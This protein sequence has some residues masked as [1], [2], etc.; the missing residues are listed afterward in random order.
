MWRALR[1][2]RARSIVGTAGALAVGF[3]AGSKDQEQR[4]RQLPAGFNACACCD[5]RPLSETQQALRP[6]LESIVGAANVKSDVQQKGSRMGEGRAFAVVKPCTIEQALKVLQE[7]VD[8]DVC[9][10]PQGANTGLTGGSVPRGAG[11]SLNRPTVVINMEQL[12]S[13]MPIDNGERIVCLAGAGIYDVLLRAESLGRESH[14]ILGSI[15]LN[16]TTAAGIAFGSGGTQ[17]CKGP[18]Y[19]ERLLYAQVGED[20]AVLLHNSLGLLGSGSE[21]YRKLESGS[22]T[23][24]DVD[25]H[26]HL[27]ASQR[28][29]KNDVCK[30]DGSVARCNADTRGPDACRSEG[31]VMILAS[32]HDTFEKPQTSDTLWIAC[33]D[34]TTA[35][36]LKAQVN[37]AGGVAD[38]PGSCEY[39]DKDAVR[40]V[41]EAGRII[42]WMIRGV[43]IGPT[44]KALWDVKLKFEASPLPFAAVVVDKLMFAFNPLFPRTLPAPILELTGACDHHLLINVA[45]YGGGE[46]KRFFERL[47]RFA[48]SHPIIVHKCSHTEKEAINYFRFAAAPA[49]RT[50]CVGSGLEGFST[51]YGLPKVFTGIP[52][53]EDDKLALR[54]RYS[55]FGCNVVHE[56]VCVKPGVDAH[57]A[58]MDLKQAVE[59]IEGMLPAE[60]GHGTEYNAPP[61]T[62]TRWKAMDPLNVFN[63]G[64]GGTSTERR[65]GDGAAA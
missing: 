2:P 4:Q 56:D 37:F 11:S 12:A 7:C 45:D 18:A 57:Q 51:D 30:L 54:M 63:P 17:T 64:I 35:H 48:A 6:K 19:T 60:H 23:Q 10:L 20:G 38:M 21:L 50:W 39:M 31:K 28:Q 44:L 22:L 1:S 36:A 61:G 62:V 49:F 13:I 41:D 29:Y 8:A 34:L 40:A 58:H 27:V 42:C 15:F 14:S 65:Y 33:K 47:D 55:H 24:E 52:Q 9:V 59:A 53:M 46:S 25:P 16:P 43:G 32:V 26:C 5:A 3:W